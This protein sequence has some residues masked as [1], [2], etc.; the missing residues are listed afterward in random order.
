MKKLSLILIL[1]VF[2]AF[3]ILVSG[4]EWHTANQVTITWDAVA[5]MSDGTAILETDIVEYKI[6][7]ANAVTD[8]DKANPTVIGITGDTSYVITLVDE[9]QYFV[10]LQT[11]RKTLVGSNNEENVIVESIIGWTDDPAIVLDG[12][13]FGIRYFLSPMVATGVRVGT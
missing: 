3:P 5:E 4:Q 13:T 10:G 6:H 8:P 11:I 1:I 9:G 2:L 12:N 7:L